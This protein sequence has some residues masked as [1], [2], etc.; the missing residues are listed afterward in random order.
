MDFSEFSRVGAVIKPADI[1]KY[2]AKVKAHLDLVAKFKDDAS[3][4]EL[5]S[6]RTQLETMLAVATGEADELNSKCIS[7]SLYII[8]TTYNRAAQAVAGRVGGAGDGG[9]RQ[10]RHAGTAPVGD[11]ERRAAPGIG[12]RGAA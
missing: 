5:E 1:R 8:L 7:R 11:G 2:I 10:P 4:D 6:I 3:L 12:L 9:P